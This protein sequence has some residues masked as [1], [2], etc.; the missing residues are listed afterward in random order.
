MAQD[1]TSPSLSGSSMQLDNSGVWGN[2]LWWKK[3][4]PQPD[5]TNFLWDFY[6]QLDEASLTA[7]QAL[8]FDAFQFLGGYNYMMGTECNYASGYWDLWDEAGGHWRRSS[9]ACPKFQTGVWHHVT[10]YTQRVAGAP[11]YTFVSITIDGTTHTTNQ[12]YAAKNVGWDGQVG[13]QYQL[14]V[15]AT[16]QAYNE[17]VDNVTL[18]TW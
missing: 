1:Q 2:A 17:W 11:S 10:L 9:V 13:V 6:F 8:E 5:A 14:D 18:S 3:L 15:N 12:A 7:A 16:G 4:G